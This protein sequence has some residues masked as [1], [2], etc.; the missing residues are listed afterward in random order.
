[1]L[2]PATGVGQEPRRVGARIAFAVGEDE[3]PLAPVGRA[4]FRR[5]EQACRKPVAHA[6]QSFGDL[7]K[8]EAQM[9]GDVLEEDE[10][11]RDLAD[12]SRDVWPEVARIGRAPPLARDRKGCARVPG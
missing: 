5:R 9:M 12:D 11:R 7:G 1:L 4:D 6:H 10:G 8:S 3:Q 2:S